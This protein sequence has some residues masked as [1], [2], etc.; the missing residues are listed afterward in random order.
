MWVVKI[1]NYTGRWQFNYCLPNA[2][3][4]WNR[5]KRFKTRM[6]RNFN[7]ESLLTN[8]LKLNMF[9]CFVYSLQW[10]SWLA[11]G[12]YMS[13]LNNDWSDL[14]RLTCICN[15][16]VA[17]SN[18]AWS[19]NVFCNESTFAFSQGETSQTLWNFGRVGWNYLAAMWAFDL[20]L[21]FSEFRRWLLCCIHYLWC[22]WMILM[23]HFPSNMLIVSVSLHATRRIY[24]SLGLK[25]FCL[26]FT[27]LLC[28][29][30][31]TFNPTGLLSRKSTG[32]LPDRGQALGLT[33]PLMLIA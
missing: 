32:C 30:R 26:D 3:K 21:E 6:A 8:S 10:R 4:V 22:I 29:G 2:P 12:T 17:S 1:V 9:D 13:V 27:C 33:V 28:M 18:L 11:H 19:I 24:P 15:A 25:N 5:F 14:N 31:F 23:K 7:V 16:E 20:L